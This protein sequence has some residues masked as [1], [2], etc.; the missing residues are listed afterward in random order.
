[1]LLENIKKF[2]LLLH[3]FYLDAEPF[4][5]KIIVFYE[6]LKPLDTLSLNKK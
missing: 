2:S 3:D 4:A 6:S 5:N 1:M